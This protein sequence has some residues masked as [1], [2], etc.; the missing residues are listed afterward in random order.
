MLKISLWGHKKE[1]RPPIEKVI[2]TIAKIVE[3][4]DSAKQKTPRV[5]MKFIKD[6]DELL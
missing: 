4:Q 3:T 6:H 5:Y 2:D 1:R